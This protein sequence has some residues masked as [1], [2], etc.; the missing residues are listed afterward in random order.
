[1]TKK[2]SSRSAATATLLKTTKNQL[3]IVLTESEILKELKKESYFSPITTVATS[4]F[5]VE[6]KS[7][8]EECLIARIWHCSS[9]YLKD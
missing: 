9:N 6:N 4:E 7:F 3:F 5:Q 2:S 8:W 1:M